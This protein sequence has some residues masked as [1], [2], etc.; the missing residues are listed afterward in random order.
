MDLQ[1]RRS[2][3]KTAYGATGGERRGARGGYEFEGENRRYMQVDNHE[4]KSGTC[5]AEQVPFRLRSDGSDYL[6]SSN[7]LIILKMSVF[8]MTPLKL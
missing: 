1:G 6:S 4:M 3:A 8:S 7:A 2:G 5:S